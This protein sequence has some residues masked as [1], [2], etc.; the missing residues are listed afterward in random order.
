MSRYIDIW[1]DV[2]KSTVYKEI[3]E[4]KVRLKPEAVFADY[5]FRMEYRIGIEEEVREVR[6]REV[7]EQDLLWNVEKSQI[8]WRREMT[9]EQMNEEI[10]EYIKKE[11]AKEEIVSYFKLWLEF[12]EKQNRKA[13]IVF[14]RVRYNDKR[15]VM[16]R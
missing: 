12:V 2:E 16:N 15:K 5:M 9:I 6:V 1:Q 7:I 3:Q 8:E 11:N 13:K 4:K 10:K 14:D